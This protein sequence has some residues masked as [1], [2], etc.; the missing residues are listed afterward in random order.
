MIDCYS[1]DALGR[2]KCSAQRLE[3][4]SIVHARVGSNPI[5]CDSFF[6]LL[7]CVVCL[8]FVCLFVLFVWCLFGVCLFVCVVCLFVLFVCV[9]CSYLYVIP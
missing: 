6:V 5:V 2:R 4:K 3:L 9:V 1:I 7:V 8:V